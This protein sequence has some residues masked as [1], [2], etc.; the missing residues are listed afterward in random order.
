VLSVYWFWTAYFGLGLACMA[1]ELVRPAH[2][3]S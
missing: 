2:K 3:V 1:F